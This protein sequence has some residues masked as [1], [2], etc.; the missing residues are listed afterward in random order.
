[1]MTLLRYGAYQETFSKAAVTGT[2]GI[3]NI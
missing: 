3:E 1:M 2:K